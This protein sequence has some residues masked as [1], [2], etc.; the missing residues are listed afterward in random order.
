MGMSPQSALWRA[1]GV[2]AFVGVGT[3][4]AIIVTEGAA[5]VII[6]EAL[7]TIGVL[8]TAGVVAFATAALIETMDA[9][10]NTATVLTV[11]EKKPKPEEEMKP[12]DAPRG[13][14]P[15]DKAGLGTK[16][17]HDIKTNAGRGSR[18][19]TGKAANLGP[20]TDFL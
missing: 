8:V 20:Y 18:D 2:L 15:I 7:D 12:D 1:G 11:N 4:A 17:I 9:T 10:V 3:V 14:I 19:W 6:P 16:A 13:T 5:S